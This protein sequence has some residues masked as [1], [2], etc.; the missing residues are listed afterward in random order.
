MWLIN[1]YQKKDAIYEIGDGLPHGISIQLTDFKL[2]KTDLLVM[3]LKVF[4]NIV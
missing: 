3:K 2:I 4:V 1:F